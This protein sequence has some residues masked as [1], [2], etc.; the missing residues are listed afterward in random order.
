M[1]TELQRDIGLVD[2]MVAEYAGREITGAWQRLKPR[3]A[4]DRERVAEGMFDAEMKF[5]GMRASW[6]RISPTT[7]AGWL[8]SA[9]AAIKA[10]GEAP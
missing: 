2:D 4:P 9:D 8:R 6:S 5:R 10:M 1:S 7:Q 3:L